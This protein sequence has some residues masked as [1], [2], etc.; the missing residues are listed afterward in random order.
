MNEAALNFL[1]EDITTK[2]GK[3]FAIDVL[4]FMRDRLL[5]YQDETGDVWNLEATP[6]E[7]TTRRLAAMDKKKY[8]EIIVAN[9]GTYKKDNAAPYYTNSSHAPVGY[10]NDVFEVLDNQDELQSLYT[11]GTVLHFYIGESISD[12]KS[13]KKLVK[14]IAENY[15]L[16]YYTITPTFS[17]CPIHGFL[18]GEHEYCPKCDA[19]LARKIH[20][21]RATEMSDL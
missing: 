6:A 18:S 15:K 13:V 17:V 9:E 4:T 7:G 1:G 10:T 19:E 20:A 2:R 16:P 5:K 14:T 12:F 11:G 3:E 21:K 8:P